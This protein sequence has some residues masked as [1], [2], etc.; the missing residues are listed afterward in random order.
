MATVV[1]P[2]SKRQ[3]LEAQKPRDIEEIPEDA[4]SVLVQ[5]RASDTGE[6][7]GPTISIPANVT[8]KQMELLVNQLLGNTEDPIPYT[9]AL[10]SDASKNDSPTL[11]IDANLYTSVLAPGHKSTEDLLT[12]VYTPQ[13]VFRVRSVTRCSAS[14]AGHGSPILVAQFSP[15]SSSRMCTGAGDNTARIW[16]CDTGTPM[17]TLRGHKNWVLAV[18]WS[19]DGKVIATGSMDSTIRLWDPKTG[20]EIG[21][22]MQS[23]T[24][25]IAALAWEPLHL[26]PAGQSP[27]LVS[28]SNDGTVKVWD[29]ALRRVQYTMSGHSGS[30]SCV[31]WG[32][33]G[34]IYSGSRDKTIKIWDAKD[35]KCFH[36]LKAHAHWVNTM[37]LSTDHVLRTGA[38]DH[39]GPA[40]SDPAEAK[41]KAKERY[42]AAA[43][44][45]GGEKLV[46]GSDDFTMYLWD[47]V[48][49]TK[50]VA[51]LH[52]HQKLVNCVA[53]SPDGR[54]ISSASF[55]NSVKLWD[56]RTGTFIATLRAHV[57][58]VYQCSWSSDSRLLVS[59]SKDTTLK[60]WDVAKRKIKEDLPGHQDE[61]YAV[62]WAPDGQ[63]VASGGKDKMTRIWRH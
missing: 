53:F 56:G 25:W 37:A 8:V 42:E 7:A 34:W 9:F 31:K 2:K 35:G 48:K 46:T 19:P 60:V 50:P 38:T 4:G 10:V 59:S 55:D 57:G 52:G 29:T 33:T 5:F 47:P 22:P 40:P 3:R 41:Q 24:K 39:T 1:P 58:A 14:I 11:D 63:M 51:K 13:A 32:G 16:D 18:A 49:S 27:R 30:V 54:Y 28:A 62:D 17:H 43:R 21:G 45:A 12:L 26:V 15:I 61:V 36:T 44:L 6:L 20:K 23:H